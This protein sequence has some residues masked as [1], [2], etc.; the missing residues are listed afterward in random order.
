VI[1]ASL[2]A[3]IDTEFEAHQIRL[4]IVDGL[5]W[6]VGKDVCETIGI[7]Q[8]KHALRQLDEDERGVMAV[9]TLGGTQQMICVN[10][11]GMY[12]LMFISRSDK[13][14]PFRRWVTHEVIPAIRATGTYSRVSTKM[15]ALAPTLTDDELIHQA[16]TVSA[17]RIGE[18]TEKVAELEPKGEFY[19]ELMDA[20]G[21]Y[22]MKA[23][24][25]ALGWGRNVMMREM[26]QHGILTGQNLPYQRHAHHFKVVPQTYT[27]P[28][29]ETFATATAYVLP[30][31]LQF[32]RRR[33]AE[34]EA[35]R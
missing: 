27:T 16:L 33:L 35:I 2:P 31:G 11:A 20:D 21:C 4:L 7:S 17:R 19:D 22:S 12:S 25:H 28:A 9:H 34:S 1:T 18:L 6:W 15:A 29:G 8:H 14:K 24:A 32:L 10:E 23:T 5:P 30:C 3:V 13:V 26:R